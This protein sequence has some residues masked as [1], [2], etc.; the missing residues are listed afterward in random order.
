M[1]L[2][3]SVANES[4]EVDDVLNRLGV[5]EAEEGERLGESISYT[6][7]TYEEGEEAEE[8]E[9]GDEENNQECTLVDMSTA[10]NEPFVNHAQEGE[11]I[12]EQVP[13][14]SHPSKK[15]S[16]QKYLT[17]KK[18]NATI[19]NSKTKNNTD[20]VSNPKLTS[21]FSS[22]RALSSSSTTFTALT[23]A[24][25]SRQRTKAVDAVT[26][27]K[28][29]IKACHTKLKLTIPQSPKIWKTVKYKK[30]LSL[31][32]EEEELAR[33]EEEKKRKEAQM[34]HHKR[35]FEMASR[36][37]KVSGCNVQVCFFQ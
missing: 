37:M 10:T 16:L 17:T 12:T 20:N 31:T 13:D 35:I 27:H 22:R 7:V 25:K 26:R 6:V 34:K 19:S 11:S 30:P 21:T 23:T 5:W 29:S 4:E 15:Q 2:E 32:R 9:E 18:F 24:A 14:Q 1:L 8:E 36:K 28:E 3:D 33:L